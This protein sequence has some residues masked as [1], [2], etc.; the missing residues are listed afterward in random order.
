MSF[1]WQ[2]KLILVTSF[3][4]FFLAMNLKSQQLGSSSF[5]SPNV[6]LLLRPGIVLNNQR[7][8][9][10]AWKL[11]E[12][13]PARQVLALK[14]PRGCLAFVPNS[15]MLKQSRKLWKKQKVW[16]CLCSFLETINRG[17]EL[18]RTSFFFFFF[19]FCAGSCQ[20]KNKYAVLCRPGEF[21]RIQ[22]LHHCSPGWKIKI[23]KRA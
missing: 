16:V 4:L 3:L 23:W 14:P 19:L 12:F 17:Q 10:A 7:L 2:E 9:T 8:L 21:F 11:S 5:C 20:P 18:K 22:R 1:C 15:W 6:S 13:F